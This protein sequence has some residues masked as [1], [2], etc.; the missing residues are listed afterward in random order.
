MRGFPLMNLLAIGAILAALLIPL[1]RVDRPPQRPLQTESLRKEEAY[2]PVTLLLRAVHAPSA[3]TLTV[4]GTPVPLRV[5]GLQQEGTARLRVED[6]SLEVA[7]KAAWP[8]GT[9]G[10]LLEVRA[11]PDGMEEQTANI[12]TEGGPVDEIVRFGWRAKP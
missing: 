8:T 4:E 1:L 5:T 6:R 10:T 12:W 9:P 3:L 7:L 2:V 11:A